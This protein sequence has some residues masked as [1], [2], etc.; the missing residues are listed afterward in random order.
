MSDQ[1]GEPLNLNFK[2]ALIARAK[3]TNDFA[4]LEEV[5]VH[6]PE[7]SAKGGAMASSYAKTDKDRAP[8][9]AVVGDDSTASGC[10]SIT[11]AAVFFFLS[12]LVMMHTMNYVHYRLPSQPPLPDLGHD[13]IPVIRPENVGDYPM[14]VSAALVVYMAFFWDRTD[15]SRALPRFLVTLGSMYV[16]R[17]FTISVTTL[18]VT[19]N[20]C[21]FARKEIASFWRNTLMG[22][23]TLGMKNVHC[24][25]LMFSGHTIMI[26]LLWE[27]SHTYFVRYRLLN[28]TVTMASL[29]AFFLIVA[30]R[31]H[32]TVDVLVGWFVTV[33]AWKLV[34]NYWPYPTLP[35]GPAASL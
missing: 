28:W 33:C 15:L 12:L 13:W 32:Y 25:D 2:N 10:A 31:S 14:L 17:L 35:V 5:I 29:T 1:A 8:R 18:P 9:R 7:D 6:T 21:R 3:S 30:T 24:G 11:L 19:D 34:P 16:L 4:K 20:H 23:L 26:V 27:V 22:L